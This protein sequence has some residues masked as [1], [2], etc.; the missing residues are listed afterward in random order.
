ME[1][2]LILKE[3]GRHRLTD[4]QKRVLL[5][6]MTVKK[7]Q[8]MTY[9]ELARVAGHPNAYR[10]VGTALRL[11]PYPIKIPCHRIVK[12]DGTPG[13]YSGIGGTRKK[14]ALLK[15]EKA[16]SAYQA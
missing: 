2:R 14:V 12:S 6:T 16:R 5:A 15:M 8:T 7:G 10:A 13:N 9:K 1:D 11:N 3:L 4:F